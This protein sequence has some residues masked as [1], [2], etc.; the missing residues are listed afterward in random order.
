MIDRMELFPPHPDL[1][2]QIS[3]PNVKPSTTNTGMTAWRRGTATAT[4]GGHDDE[5]MEFDFWRKAIDVNNAAANA[6]SNS[7]LVKPLA[8]FD[9]SLSTTANITDS[10]A[11]SNNNLF[12]HQNHHHHQLQHQHQ[13]QQPYHSHRDVAAMIRPIR[14]IPVYQH[15]PSFP[16]LHHNHHLLANGGGGGGVVGGNSFV[17]TT[18]V[19]STAMGRSRFFSR[20]PAKRSMRA[21]RM[22]WTTT[23]HARFVHAVELLGGHE[24][25]Y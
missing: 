3:P 5:A 15:T 12:L 11:N 21:P 16:F 19:A 2:L 14:G 17:D 4:G 6:S 1:S 7:A 24:S 23:L 8:G 13:H 20:F 22:R 10:T 18:T 9:L 25:V